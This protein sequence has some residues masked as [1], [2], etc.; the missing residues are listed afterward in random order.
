VDRKR[1]EFPGEEVIWASKNHVTFVPGLEAFRDSTRSIFV[2]GTKIKNVL[3]LQLFIAECELS[4]PQGRYKTRQ[5]ET[6]GSHRVCET[7]SAYHQ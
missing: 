3:Q 1:G 6:V 7:N 2:F 4:K 5:K